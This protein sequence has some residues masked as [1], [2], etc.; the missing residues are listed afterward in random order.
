M[1]LPTNGVREIEVRAGTG[2]RRGEQ[3]PASGP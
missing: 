2:G 3:S 1:E